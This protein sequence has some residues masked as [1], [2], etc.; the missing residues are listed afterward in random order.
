MLAWNRD[1]QV[2]TYARIRACE[3]DPRRPV[4]VPSHDAE[5]FESLPHAPQ[6]G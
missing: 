2:R 6:P 4:V 5:A 3:A 1:E